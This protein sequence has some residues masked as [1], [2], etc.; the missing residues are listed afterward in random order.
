MVEY[1]ETKQ[2]SAT[3]EARRA[4]SGF[5][6]RFQAD[7]KS[8][9]RLPLFVDPYDGGELIFLWFAVDE[10]SFNAVVGRLLQLVLVCSVL[11]PNKEG[12]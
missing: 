3:E 4:V 10:N 6:E 9:R 2:S 11:C 12:A 1:I 5:N 7:R 8:T